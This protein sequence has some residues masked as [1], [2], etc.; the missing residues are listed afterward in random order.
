MAVQLP[1]FRCMW[2]NGTGIDSHRGGPHLIGGCWLCRCHTFRN[3]TPT[4]THVAGVARLSHCRYVPTWHAGRPSP[5]R[6]KHTAART[7]S[8][9]HN[10]CIAVA[11]M[12]RVNSDRDRAPYRVEDTSTGRQCA[13]RCDGVWHRKRYRTARD[14]FDAVPWG[15]ICNPQSLS[16]GRVPTEIGQLRFLQTL[17]LQDNGLSGTTATLKVVSRANDVVQP[18]VSVPFCALCRRHPN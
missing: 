1:I 4:A 17:R 16:T 14:P 13:S 9:T 2:W 6:E 8:R 15:K 18:R 5:K 12:I 7:L 3:R 10:D 11:V